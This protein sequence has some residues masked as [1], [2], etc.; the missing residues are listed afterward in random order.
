VVEKHDSP[1]SYIVEA[2][3]GNVY[4]RNSK[5][6]RKSFVE[7]PKPNNT[8]AIFNDS[9]AKTMVEPE[10]SPPSP[11]VEQSR[12]VDIGVTEL[13]A[14]TSMPVIQTTRSGRAVKPVVRLNL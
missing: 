7:V 8:R 13:D 4:R 14:Q 9:E 2:E 12:S 6:I 10:H 11:G 1:R 5:H 3:D